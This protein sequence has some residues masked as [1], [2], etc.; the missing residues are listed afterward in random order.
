MARDIVGHKMGTVFSFV[1]DEE[2]LE[3]CVTYLECN[4]PAFS[5]WYVYFLLGCPLLWFPSRGLQIH[6]SFV[7]WGLSPTLV[8]TEVIEPHTDITSPVRARR[9]YFLEEAVVPQMVKV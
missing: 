5:T 6:T 4:K 7:R 2:D 1:A 3:R 8:L 9:E